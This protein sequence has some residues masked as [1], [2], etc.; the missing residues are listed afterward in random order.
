MGNSRIYEDGKYAI[1]DVGTLY[2]GCK[3]TFEEL[4]ECEEVPFKFRLVCERYLLPE[5]DLEDTLETHLYYLDPKSFEV[6]ILKQLKA[7]IKVNLLAVKENLFG[8]ASNE[9]ITKNLGVDE[10]CSLKPEEKEELGM[11]IQE[12][13]VSKF[14]LMAF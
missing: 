8:Y 14:A 6:K 3:F 13:A 10:L 7:K 5:G 12:I 9:Y 1:Q 2:V 11:V 4:L